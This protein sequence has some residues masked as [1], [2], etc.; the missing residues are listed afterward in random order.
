M[1]KN[2]PVIK[3]LAELNPHVLDEHKEVRNG[4]LGEDQR[5]LEEDELQINEDVEDIDDGQIGVQ[6]KAQTEAVLQRL[7]QKPQGPLVRWERFLPVR[8]LEVLLVENDDSTRHV[9]S[10]LLWNC[11]YEGY[12]EV[13]IMS[14]LSMKNHFLLMVNMLSDLLKWFIYYVF[15]FS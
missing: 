1:N 13:V 14:N 9:V 4:L 12:S 15:F 2:C 5:L 6:D 10:A 3:W 7:Q 8:S 11:G